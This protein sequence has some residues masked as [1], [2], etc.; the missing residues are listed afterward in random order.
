MEQLRL[1]F[2]PGEKMSEL[3]WLQQRFRLPPRPEVTKLLIHAQFIT[4]TTELGVGNH[5]LMDGGRPVST[6]PL[7]RVRLCHYAARSV[8]QYERASNR[9]F[10][11]TGPPLTTSA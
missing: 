3:G 11:F 10:A 1:R 6:Q 2:G 5:S 7:D 8:A 9:N 4:R